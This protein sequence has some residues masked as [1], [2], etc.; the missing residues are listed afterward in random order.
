MK[1]EFE[2]KFRFRKFRED[3]PFISNKDQSH[4]LTSVGFAFRMFKHFRDHG[5]SKK[6]MNQ[7]KLFIKAPILDTMTGTGDAGS[8]ETYA[9]YN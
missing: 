1:C 4:V 5:F 7:Q 8:T 9:V 3:V 6:S 2:H